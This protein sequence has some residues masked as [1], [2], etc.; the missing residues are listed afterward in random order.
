MRRINEQIRLFKGR[1]SSFSLYL[2]RNQGQLFFPNSKN[3]VTGPGPSCK[4]CYLNTNADSSAFL[5]LTL[6]P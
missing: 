4:I 6:G 1:K 3:L 5:D 2:K